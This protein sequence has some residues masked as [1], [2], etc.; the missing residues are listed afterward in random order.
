[1][2]FRRNVWL[3]LLSGLPGC[4][5]GRFS[6]RAKTLL[7]RSEIFVAWAATESLE[8]FFAGAKFVDDD[9]M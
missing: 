4:F 9:L 7:M 3:L 6:G 5:A 1:M 8:G 2:G